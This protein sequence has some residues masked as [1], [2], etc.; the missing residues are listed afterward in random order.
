MRLPYHNEEGL[1]GRKRKYPLLKVIGILLGILGSL[2]VPLAGAAQGRNLL[3]NPGFEP[4][5][6]TSIPGKDNCF[7]ANGWTAWYIEGT[8]EETA[9]GYLHAPE[10]KGATR[11]DFPYDRV[12]GG[13]T[14]QQWFRSFAT[15]KAGVYQVVPNIAPGA[16]YRFGAWVMIW[17]CHYDSDK[18]K[19]NCQGA[20]SGNPSP[21]RIRVGI[22][23][24]GG[25]DPFSANVVWS[26]EGNPVDAWQLFQV[27]AV[28]QA[29]QMTVFVYSNP[30]FR[31]RNNDVYV[32]DASLVMV[33]PP[34]MPKPKPTN[35]P[36]P[37]ATPMATPEPTATPTPEATATP[38]PTPTPV[39][40]SLRVLAF[41]DRNANGVRDAGEPLLAGARVQVLDATNKVVLTGTTE[42]VGPLILSG[43][44]PGNYTVLSAS[45]AGYA[46]LPI[47]RWAVALAAGAEA[48]IAFA[49]RPLPTATPLPT[50]SPTAPPTPAPTATPLPTP[51]PPHADW[52]QRLYGISG[53]LVAAVACIL[54]GVFWWRRRLR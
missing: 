8:R 25:T 26:P 42:G 18:D 32:D 54:A 15:Y 10:Y 29:S 9:Q 20:R 46:P 41:E 43:L 22:D 33:A 4:P 21:M 23:P 12:H 1:M 30:E 50:S 36:A 27:E 17:S 11:Q 2:F 19:K 7:I 39:A 28:A 13:D 49:H 31:N 24:K 5:Y 38:L 34:P 37:T 47:D 48:E 40:A 3:A 52:G 51:L 14:A 6:V 16:R 53:I 45:P 44:A 35:T